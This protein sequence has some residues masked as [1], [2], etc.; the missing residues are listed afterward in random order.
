MGY[1]WDIVILKSNFNKQLYPKSILHCQGIETE[2]SYL[3]FN[4]TNHCTNDHT[5]Y[6]C[7]TQKWYLQYCDRLANRSKKI[8]PPTNQTGLSSAPG[9]FQSETPA[10]GLH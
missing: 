8:W 7:H 5:W 10:I 9:S 6:I 3:L 1:Q 4:N 2:V